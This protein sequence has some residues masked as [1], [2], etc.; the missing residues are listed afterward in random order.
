ML[1]LLRENTIAILT[2]S[3]SALVFYISWLNKKMHEFMTLQQD[4]NAFHIY[5]IN[6]NTCHIIQHLYENN[7]FTKMEFMELIFGNC[8]SYK[9]HN[10]LFSLLYDSK[11]TAND[12]EIYSEEKQIPEMKLLAKHYKIATEGGMDE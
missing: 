3:V 10:P 5:K 8:L 11:I 4:C 6:M 7:K 12:I 2:I 1:E 9:D